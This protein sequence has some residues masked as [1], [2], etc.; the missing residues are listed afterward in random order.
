VQGPRAAQ[1]LLDTHVVPPPRH[2]VAKP[3]SGAEGL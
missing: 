1:G 2:P 3:S